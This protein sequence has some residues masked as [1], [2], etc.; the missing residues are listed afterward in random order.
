M[1]DEKIFGEYSEDPLVSLSSDQGT[2][3]RSTWR[4]LR[5]LAE[6]ILEENAVFF[7]QLTTAIVIHPL[8]HGLR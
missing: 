6:I 7:G 4:L 3:R 2:N 5:K 8:N 1:P